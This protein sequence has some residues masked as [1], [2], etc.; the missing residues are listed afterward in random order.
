MSSIDRAEQQILNTYGNHSPSTRLLA[1]L[2]DSLKHG[3]DF[4]LH[5]LYE[6]SH[7]DFTLAIELLSDWRL[8]RYVHQG[9]RSD[10]FHLS[11]QAAH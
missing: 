8:Q 7:G 1:E 10:P 6:M 11:G 4:S 9:R 2:L 5:S 3:G